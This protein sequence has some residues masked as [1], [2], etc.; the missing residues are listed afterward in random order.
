MAIDPKGLVG[1]R[2]A[3]LATAFGCSTQAFLGL[4]PG[5]VVCTA[6][7]FA[8]ALGLDAQR[9][10]RFACVDLHARACWSRAGGG[11]PEPALA[12]AGALGVAAG[13]G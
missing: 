5:Q 6:E 11:D 4:D 1:D 10:L 2:N 3:D 8:A 9:L 12:A 13:M 7:Q